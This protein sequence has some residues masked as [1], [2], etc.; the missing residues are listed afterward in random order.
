MAQPKRRHA[1]HNTACALAYAAKAKASK[2]DMRA[3]SRSGIEP[4]GSL[5]RLPWRPSAKGSVSLAA[6]AAKAAAAGN[7]PMSA[8]AATAVTAPAAAAALLTAVA[9][10]G[11]A[12]LSK[13]LVRQASKRRKAG[14]GNLQMLGAACSA[15]GSRQHGTSV[16][17]RAERQP[18]STAGFRRQLHRAAQAQQQ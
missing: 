10:A 16:T 4:D 9:A 6:A 11:M 12:A 8:A 2:R 18:T 14:C 15:I 1:R 7:R 3:T 13:V 17:D 5:E